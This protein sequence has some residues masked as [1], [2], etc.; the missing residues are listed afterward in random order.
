VKI[1]GFEFEG[2]AELVARGFAIA[3]LEQRISQVFV[4]IGP[5]R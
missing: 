3:G 4:D 5:I 2:F 1:R